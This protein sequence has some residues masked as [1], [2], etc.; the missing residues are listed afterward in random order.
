MLTAV[1]ATVCF[2]DLF[3]NSQLA[4]YTCNKSG[5]ITYF[6]RSAAKL[7]GRSLEPD[8]E[9]WSG[10][11]RTYYP[12]GNP[13][14]DEQHPASLALT[15]NQPVEGVELLIERP[16]RTFTNV[17]IYTRPITEN[18][19]LTGVDCMMVDISHQKKEE[20][21]Q[22]ILSAIVESSDDA[23]VSKN[24]N[25]II[26][27]WNKGAEKIFGYK[28]DE[29]IGKHISILIPHDLLEEEE[30]IINSIKRGQKI[31]HFQTTRVSKFGKK[32]P[33]SITV[34]CIKDS[35][36]NI[37]GASKIARDISEQLTRE[38]LLRQGAERLQT[39]NAIGKVISEKMDLQSILQR[40][41]DATT[42]ITGAGFG[43][44]FYNAVDEQGEVF[45]L[46]TLSGAP[47]E[48]FEKLGMPRNTKLFNVTFTG[49]GIV[50]SD[51][52][53]QDP[54]YGK[55]APHF[56]M[57][58]GHLPVVSYLAVPVIRGDGSVVGGLFFGHPDVG[59]FT[60]EHEDMVAMI[61]SQAAVSLDNS[62][63]FEEV[64]SLSAKK[65][66]F[67][68]LASHELKTPLT[69][70]K[71]YLQ[72]L[73]GNEKDALNKHFMD[74]SLKQVDRLASL[75]GDLLDVTKVV[76]GKLQLSFEEFDL[77][78]LVIDTIE[79]FRYAN[80]THTI[81]LDSAHEALTVHADKQRIEQVLINLIT[82][83]IK[84]SPDASKVTISVS[85]TG[86]AALVKI[87]DEGVGL[88]PEQQ[89]NIFTRFYRAEGNPNISGLG[90]GLYLA[91]EIIE[92]HQGHI[93]VVSE[94]GKGS[95]FFFTLPLHQQ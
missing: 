82:N 64:K 56:G 86:T 3:A 8:T 59:R 38:E 40:V 13:V 55:S 22:G 21:K 84:Y 12:N 92:R 58:K 2:K 87:K 27:S 28:E 43:A 93:S 26:T 42:H 69:T 95:E 77:Q 48:M 51:D 88:T 79:T 17:L 89:G 61:A 76:A 57:P 52:I 90:L 50:R 37:I 45:T 71:G 83:A 62:R 46:F 18:G 10:A 4:I 44:F 14:P 49:E 73:Q 11:W 75:V 74:K 81:Q 53:R 91:K 9:L 65:D 29:V 39:L 68:A 25:G 24:L 70:L 7:W 32:I 30:V 85:T 66:E 63:L 41:T 35:N 94:L 67:I 6:N 1:S 72:L 60:Q 19:E 78:K 23:I 80:L 47:K 20:A 34:S 33:V 54:R 31:D 36:G 16:D 5:L 15:N